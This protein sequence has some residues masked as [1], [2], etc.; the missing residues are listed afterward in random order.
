[1]AETV[2]TDPGA[3]RLKILVL[4]TYLTREQAGAA[5]SML[6]IIE[7]LS[8]ARWAEVTV[9]A[10]T[11][12]ES[13]IPPN[14]RLVR[15]AE[16][17]WPKSFWR[18]FPLPD[19]WHAVRVL[20]RMPL[21]DFDLCYTQN[22][23]LGLAFRRHQPDAPVASHPGAI[24]WEREVLD[25]GDAPLR[26]L[27]LH[28]RL[29]R[30]IE[31]RTHR[32]A[33]WHHLASSALVAKIRAGSF[34][35]DENL[36]EVVPLPVDPVRFDPSRV[37]R[38]VRAEL[39]LGASDFVVVVVARLLRWKRVDAV[40]RAVAAQPRPVKLLVVG[41]GPERYNLESLAKDL[42]IEDRVRFV[43][44]QDPP[45]YLA[46]ANLFVLPSLIE[47][48]GLV[49]IEAMMMG[50][51]C[52]GRRYSPPEVLSAASEVIREGEYGFCVNDDAELAQ[53]IEQLSAD[54]G[55]CHELGM[56]ARQAALRE[57]TPQRYIDRLREIAL[58]NN[59][60]VP[61]HTRLRAE[62]EHETIACE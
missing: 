25:E 17:T 51:P 23:P 18:L 15:L 49:Y 34:S 40:V 3:R 50:L 39:G 52:I 28:A 19:Y 55:R 60:R 31:A 12:D 58:G 2:A 10:F 47:S 45:P 16:A 27:R 30:L 59:G 26:W 21:A 57:F 38:N 9:A 14:V 41:D 37:T 61:A 7:A 13:L 42:R 33:R 29:A 8:R 54:P 56:R 11:W 5:H 24:L 43:G 48:F 36:F 53:R 4:G 20:E 22:M 32:Q 46:A 35:I 6:T 62:P 44:R 1:M